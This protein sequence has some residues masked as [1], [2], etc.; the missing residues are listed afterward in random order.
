M[1]R[2]QMSFFKIPQI[3]GIISYNE[4]SELYINIIR[5][6]MQ[7]AILL[8]ITRQIYKMIV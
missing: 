5:G 2:K 8:F 4:S 3:I 1:H 6:E 7:A